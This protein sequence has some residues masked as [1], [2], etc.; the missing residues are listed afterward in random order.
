M[1][2]NCSYKSDNEPNQ[3][4]KRLIDIFWSDIYNV[5]VMEET[6]K[7]VADLSIPQPIQ[8]FIESMDRLIKAEKKVSPLFVIEPY[9]EALEKLDPNYYSEKRSVFYQEDCESLA[10]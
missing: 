3:I 1:Q 5:Q 2:L 9:G 10:E 8:R 6:L 4:V 7:I